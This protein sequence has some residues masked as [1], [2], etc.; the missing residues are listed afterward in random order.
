MIIN[1]RTKPLSMLNLSP[2]FSRNLSLLLSLI[3]SLLTLPAQVLA[4]EAEQQAK[5]VSIKSAKQENIMPTIW[6]PGNVTS[7]LDVNIS[8][9]QN[10][11]LVWI[12]DVGDSVLKGQTIAKLDTQDL[13]FEL[14][15]SESQLR[16]Q[17][18]NTVYLE[19]QKKRLHALL[20]NNSTA[21][22]E[23]D[24]TMRDL[25]IAKE[26]LSSL[27]IKI[28]RIKLSIDK[29]NLKA[30]FDGQVNQ[31][32]KQAGEFISMGQ[33]LIQIVDPSSIDISVAAPLSVYPFMKKGDEMLVKLNN[34][35]VTFPVRTWSP[36][37]NQSTR[38]FNVLLDASA[39]KLVDAGIAT[40][41]ISSHQLMSGESVSVA[42][43]KDLPNISTMVPRDA[44]ILREQQTFVVT[45]DE[46]DSA[47]KVK[48][49]VGRGVDE[50]ISVAGQI[51]AGDK[52]VTR[53][54][55]NLQDGD[56]V[57]FDIAELTTDGVVAAK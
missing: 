16:Q 12:L 45:I 30:P 6:L 42:L 51:F 55:E 36:A 2:R 41:H 56:K 18:A 37:G 26:E 43:P 34:Q 21:R 39:K 32:M 15:E 27:D 10:G 54:G 11:L 35:L 22:I 46:Q 24:R 17:Q 8:S 49:V 25:S 9:E 29:A 40:T 19:K 7:R 31:R 1:K 33:E 14:A 23:F 28:N 57:R 52:V 44:L 13:E 48:V 47:H 5:L 38:T 50:W 4:A 3:L 53:G 20:K